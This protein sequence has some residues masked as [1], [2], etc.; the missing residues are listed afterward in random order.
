MLCA[1]IPQDF[2][3]VLKCFLLLIARIGPD[4][5]AA[6]DTEYPHVVFSSIKQN[7]RYLAVL[8]ALSVVDRK[9]WSLNWFEAYLNSIGHLPVVKDV[10]PDMVQFL[11]EELQHERFKII[12]PAAM[13][14]AA[15]VSVASQLALVYP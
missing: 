2:V 7:P 5:W 11:C 10:L 9:E 12:R 8:Q 4:L 14:I 6:E 3:E 13:T 15:R 1:T